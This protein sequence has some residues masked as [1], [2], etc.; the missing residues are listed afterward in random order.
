M[1]K[2]NALIKRPV[3]HFS[4]ILNNHKNI[5]TIC[6]YTASIS[7]PSTEQYT[8]NMFFKGFMSDGDYI[9]FTHYGTAHTHVHAASC[10]ANK[11]E[12][13]AIKIC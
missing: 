13:R 3:H 2:L 9:K 6:R 10:A 11:N 1:K 7:I 12:Y 8:L 5:A 4:S